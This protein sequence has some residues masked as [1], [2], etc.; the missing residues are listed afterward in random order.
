MTLQE[1]VQSGRPF[2][3]KSWR[4]LHGRE[5]WVDKDLIT[6]RFKFINGGN[7]WMPEYNDFARHDFVIKPKD[8]LE[9]LQDIINCHPGSVAKIEDIKKDAIQYL[10]KHYDELPF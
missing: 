10:E 5:P 3:S 2:K 9:I 6:R 1:A 8:H 4:S 7:T